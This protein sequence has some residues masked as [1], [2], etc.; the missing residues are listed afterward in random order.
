MFSITKASKLIFAIIFC[1]FLLTICPG[2]A[3]AITLRMNL[4]Q[5]DSESDGIILGTVKSV[6]CQWTDDQTSIF[7]TV[8]VSV[9]NEVKGNTGQKEVTVI[10][11]GG[12]VD[13]II[14]RISVMPIFCPG[15]HVLLFLNSQV[16]E[17]MS[18]TPKKR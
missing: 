14:H 9:E 13:G 11:P 1:L 2:I 17:R 12:E 3:D 5:L 6:S 15:E 7:T 18:E 8:V 4:H 16:S 10:V